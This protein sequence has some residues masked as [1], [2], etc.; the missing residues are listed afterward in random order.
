[1]RHVLTATAVGFLA[2][3]FTATASAQ[4]YGGN[5][6]GSGYYVPNIACQQPNYPAYPSNYAQPQYG[7]G[8]SYSTPSVGLGLS[9]SPA[10]G[11][12]FGLYTRPSYAPNFYPN[13]G[14]SPW[15]GHNHHHHHGHR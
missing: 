8:F 15:Q 10:Y 1:M 13:R 6:P 9:Y 2:L 12:N 3:V 14:I 5:Y 4:G 11:S 7:G